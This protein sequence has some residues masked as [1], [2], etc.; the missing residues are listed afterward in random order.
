MTNTIYQQDDPE[1]RRDTRENS[2]AAPTADTTNETTNFPES[3]IVLQ[4]VPLPSFLEGS[5]D[6]LPASPSPN[7]SMNRSNL[8]LLTAFQNDAVS[9]TPYTHSGNQQSNSVVIELNETFPAQL[10]SLKERLLDAE[11]RGT[12]LGNNRP[13]R[14]LLDKYTNADMPPIH[15]AHPT[16]ILDHLDVNLANDWENL[17]K[18]KL[19][20]QPFGPDAKNVAK[21]SM[22][23]TLLFAAIV[24]ITNSRDVSVIALKQKTS[25]YKTPFSFLVYNISDQ[26]AHTLL[27][28]RVWSSPSITFS[29][30]TLHPTC[31]KYFFSIKGLAT[32]NK[33]E[34][35]KA[36][37]EVW[38]DQ[39]SLTFLQAICQN[40]P[41]NTKEQASAM[42]LQFVTSLEVERLDT[43]LRGNTI[44]PIFNIYANGQLIPNDNTWSKIR[45]FY[46]SRTYTLQA[47]DIGITVIAPFRCGICHAA[48]HPRGLCPFPVLEGWNGPKR[49]EETGTL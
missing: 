22:I 40:F 12:N 43:K 25:S 31:S 15:Y 11:E 42:L 2:L 28:R 32:M 49:H 9:S 19:L 20:V 18:G 13:T 39:E 14:N 24:E 36:V 33:N 6:I 3:G 46:T 17:P 1:V 35:F 8:D 45:A 27:E 21:H 47:Q 26:Q 29:V 4:P 23:K 5:L 7:T 10:L 16:A 44:A 30:S 48:D 37:N 38:R 41:E 34:V